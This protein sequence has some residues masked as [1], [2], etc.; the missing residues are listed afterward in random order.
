MN[1][2]MAAFA[3]STA[4]VSSGGEAMAQSYS[5]QQDGRT[6]S[7]RFDY[8]A[9]QD[10]RYRQQQERDYRESEYER[11]RR[12]ARNEQQRRDNI[13]TY[14]PNAYPSDQRSSNWADR[15]LGCGSNFNNRSATNRLQRG[16]DDLIGRDGRRIGRA[17]GTSADRRISESQS[18]CLIGRANPDRQDY[19]QG[20]MDQRRVIQEERRLQ[21]EGSR[22]II[23]GLDR[24]F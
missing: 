2:L 17:L 3:L 15:N 20:R 18:D 9:E 14:H 22:A 4:I 8:Y 16:F 1:K 23:R 21:R 6:A 24:I 12:D 5:Q 11:G 7:G 13:E 10:A 19:L